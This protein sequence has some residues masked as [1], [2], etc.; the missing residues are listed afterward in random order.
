MIFRKSKT[1]DIKSIMKIIRQ[2]QEFFK[3]QERSMAKWL[4]K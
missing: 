1:S 4:S 3:N 2:A